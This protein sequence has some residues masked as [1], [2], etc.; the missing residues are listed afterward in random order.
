ML[1]NRKLTR[2]LSFLLLLVF[3][4]SGS[5]Y[6]SAAAQSNKFDKF[7]QGFSQKLD[8]ALKRSADALDKAVVKLFTSLNKSDALNVKIHSHFYDA[9]IRR[10]FISLSGTG[11]FRG[12]LPF[13]ISKGDFQVSCDKEVSYDFR[14]SEVRHHKNQLKFAFD[15]AIVVSLDRISYELMKKVPHLAASG[16]LTPA[17]NLLTNFLERL[18]I[19]ILS[20]AISDT[21]RSFSTVAI[22][23]TG[24]DLLNAAGKN[25]QLRKVIKS[26]VDDGTIVSFLGLS[27]LKAAA[28][29]LV[30]VAGASLGATV[31]SM[32]A[33]GP[34][35]I[36]GAYLGSQILSHIA[37]T[38]V[39]KVAVKIPTIRNLKKIHRSYLIL[40]HNPEDLVAAAD[41]KEATTKVLKKVFYELNTEKFRLFHLV[42]ERIDKFHSS[43]RMA[44]VQLLKGIQQKLLFQVT[45]EGDWYFAKFYYQL[46]KYV[47]EWNLEDQLPFTT[48][49]NALNN[50]Q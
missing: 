11:T 44:F 32:V 25:K 13:K 41:H 18:N 28:A 43:E 48:A 22:A 46:K 17:A 19:G 23:R 7:K 36:I 20:E 26:A 4:A 50:R 29:S 15:G 34:G 37:A 21:F 33:P 2:A 5:F 38:V 35:S 6:E 8:Q 40:R 1:K 47:I 45:N 3:L 24:A 27:I 12:K 16:A 42:L 39:Y 14:V 9:R 31:G 49:P 30:N 10:Y